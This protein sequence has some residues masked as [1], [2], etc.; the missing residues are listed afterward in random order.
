MRRRSSS[1]LSWVP[2]AMESSDDVQQKERESGVGASPARPKEEGQR[3][4]RKAGEYA[5]GE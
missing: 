4:S 5:A 3:N 1:S 2:K